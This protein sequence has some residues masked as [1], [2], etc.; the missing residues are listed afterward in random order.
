MSSYSN[1]EYDNFFI[2]LSHKSKI[3][4]YDYEKKKIFAEYF[5]KGNS[6][7]MEVTDV[8]VSNNRQ[9]RK[10]LVGFNNGIIEIYGLVSVKLLKIITICN[11]GINSFFGMKNIALL[12]F[13]I[14]K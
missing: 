1:L 4:L 11:K 8:A 12:V 14:L 13:K 2:F 3:K 9:E 5:N 7:V 6:I 10:L